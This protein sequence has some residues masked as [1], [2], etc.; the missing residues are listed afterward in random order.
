MLDLLRVFSKGWLAKI[1]IALLVVSFGV[2]GI[3]GSLFFGNQSTVV[4]VGETKVDAVEYRFAYE[5]QLAN[6][7]STLQRRLTREEADGLGLRQSVLS[8]MVAGAILDENARKMGLGISEE[9]L[10]KSISE[11]PTFRDLS[12]NFSRTALRAALRNAGLSENEYIDSRKRISI[13]NQFLDGTA[14]A[15]DM[16]KAYFDA[17]GEYENETRT[18]E[19]TT[20]GTE[21]VTETREPNGSELETYFEENKESYK[22]PEYRKLAIL[23]LLPEDLAKPEDVTDE[24]VRA[25]YDARKDNLRQP[26]RREIE[27]L[28]LNPGSRGTVEQQLADGV[29][30][31]EIV[32]SQGKSLEDINLGLLTRDAIPDSSLADAAFSASTGDPTE[33]VDGVFGPVL[34]RVVRIEPESTTPFDEVK[35]TLRKELAEE[36]AVEDVFSIFNSVEEERGAGETIEATGKTLNIDTEVMDGIDAGGRDKTGKIVTAI[37]EL[38]KVLAEAFQAQPGDDTR[39]V[40]IGE[41]GF[42]WFDVL[43][44]V[45]ERQKELA[46]VREDV[47]TA[48]KAQQA[49]ETI[50][51]LA[52]DI[53]TRVEAGTNFNEVLSE[54]LPTDSLGNKITT[55]TTEPLRRNAQSPEFPASA[56][57][58]G[59]A[60]AKGK[61]DTLII[62]SNRHVVYRVADVVTPKNSNVENTLVE[63]VN[64]AASQDILGQL[65]DHLQSRENVLINQTAAEIA[66]TPGRQHGTGY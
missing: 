30:F 44:I 61:M 9:N 66:L 62:G 29:S 63:G 57:R 34:L 13:R 33:V 58:S 3:S 46:E 31:A 65:V 24:E 48:W 6:L 25:S 35:D 37:P 47:V 7:S 40:E 59:F 12:G 51:K 32:E 22:A 38:R 27:Q 14:A 42:I 39:A 64:Q 2:W 8:Q 36:R 1:L 43:E 56:V 41:N 10:A 16:P 50:E 60:K 54:L 21:V 5:N 4:E 52:R 18:F 17:L 49:D 11:D 15:L 28:V 45:P 26:E 20:I 53:V 55:S 19:Y 23:K